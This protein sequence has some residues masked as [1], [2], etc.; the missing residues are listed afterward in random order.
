[1][2]GSCVGYAF[3]IFRWYQASLAEACLSL[4]KYP[5]LLRIHLD[6]NYPR[7]HFKSWRPEAFQSSVFQG[8][9]PLQS[10]LVAAWLTA[11][12]SLEVSA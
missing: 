5:N 8:T 6:A 3:G 2:V 11:Q 9:W 12:P 1:M 10:M 4:D 7:E